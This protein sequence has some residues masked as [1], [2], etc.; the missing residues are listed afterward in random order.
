VTKEFF[1]PSVTY[2]VSTIGY[3]FYLGLGVPDVMHEA[4]LNGTLKNTTSSQCM[5]AYGINFVSKSRNIL[6]VTTDA[7]TGNNSLLHVKTWSARDEIP[8]AWICGD[9]W[10]LSPYSDQ[11]PSAVCT[12]SIASA[13]TSNWTLNSHHISYCMVQEVVEECQLSFSLLIMVIVIIVNATKTCISKSTSP[14]FL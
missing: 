8:Y 5:E 11:P 3:D 14:T 10:S 9:G 1:S 13:A 4:F 6:L 12:I 7:D 2:N